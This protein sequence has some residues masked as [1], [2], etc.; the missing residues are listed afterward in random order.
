MRPFLISACAVTAFSFAVAGHADSNPPAGIP[1]KVSQN[2]LKRHPA[3]HDMQVGHESHFGQQ[4]L[5]V[6]YKDETGQQIMELFT[7]S[8]HLLTNELLIEDFNEIYPQVIAVL[9]KE[10]PRH[11]LKLKK[12]ELIGNPNGVGEEYEIYLTADGS[13]WKVSITGDGTL[14]DKQPATP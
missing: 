5:E 12:A 4:L 14:L 10:F 9:K 1:E 7:A 3:A 8:G 13:D 2:I 11:A 6:G